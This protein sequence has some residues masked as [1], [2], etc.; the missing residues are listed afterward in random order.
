MASIVVWR[1]S[2]F[3]QIKYM[4]SQV[5]ACERCYLTLLLN[6]IEKKTFSPTTQWRFVTDIVLAEH[7]R[8]ARA[9]LYGSHV[10]YSYIFGNS[11][12]TRY[13]VYSFR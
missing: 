9:V 1:G 5:H 12:E 8:A 4:K 6:V 2:F 3:A 10:L 13:S 7:K 11:F